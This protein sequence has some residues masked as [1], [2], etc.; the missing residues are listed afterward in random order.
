[1]AEELYGEVII[2]NLIEHD[3]PTIA[4]I[5]ALMQRFLAKLRILLVNNRDELKPEVVIEEYIELVYTILGPLELAYRDKPIFT[6]RNDDSNFISL[7]AY[8]DHLLGEAL[9]QAYQH[10]AYPDKLC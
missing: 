4:G 8:R 5:I 1:M 2:T 7:A 6:I 10:A 9:R 3:E